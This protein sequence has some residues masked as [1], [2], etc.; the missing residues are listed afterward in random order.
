MCYTC[1]RKY[2]TA[3]VM[4]YNHNIIMW[5]K[6][7]F[8]AIKCLTKHL[9]LNATVLYRKSLKFDIQEEV[10]LDTKFPVQNGGMES[11]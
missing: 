9:A 6:V 11:N 5:P 1:V 10:L 8:S 3:C 7:H 2:V 4:C